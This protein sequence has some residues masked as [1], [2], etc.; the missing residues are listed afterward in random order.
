MAVKLV[1]APAGHG[2]TA[3]VIDAIRALLPLSPARVLVPD[4]IQAA[5]F[6]RRTAQSG[7]VLGVQVQT[8]YGLY[9]DVLALAGG[10]LRLPLP[11]PEQGMAHLGPAV[12]Q[13]LIQ[14]M[15]E[16]LYDSGRLSYYAPLRGSPG[17]A[18]LLG[19]LF[20]ELKRARVFP[21]DLDRALSEREPR[22][23]ELARVYAAYQEWLLKT[24][25][26][27]ADGQG[28]LAA[29][30]L[31][32]NASLF[33]DLALLVVDGFDEFNPT[34]LHLLRLLARF[35]LGGGRRAPVRFGGGGPRT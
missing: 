34:Q 23:V 19:D 1:V 16:I 24:G 2:K 7:G 14:C 18:R 10:T 30:A 26:I 11:Q 20:G 3:Y 5:A 8:F 32:Q 28:W 6:R 25:W 22:L 29:I 15:T 27:D 31:E 33:S 21:E 17:F 9:A 12:R 4:Q 13:R 35:R